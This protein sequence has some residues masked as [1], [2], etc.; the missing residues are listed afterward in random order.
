VCA[1]A[2]LRS[3]EATTAALDAAAVHAPQSLLALLLP[4]RGAASEQPPQAQQAQPQRHASPPRSSPEALSQVMLLGAVHPALAPHAVPPCYAPVHFA[5][6]ASAEAARAAVAAATAGIAAACAAAAAEAAR[7]D[8]DAAATAAA[9]AAA[10]AAQRAA[11]AA[12]GSWPG[13]TRS[14]AGET[15]VYQQQQHAQ[16]A[17]H[18]QQ[19]QQQQ[20][21]YRQAAAAA[22]ALCDDD[23]DDD[24]GFADAFGGE[25]SLLFGALPAC[26]FGAGAAS[27][28]DDPFVTPSALATA[29]SRLAPFEARLKFH[30]LAPTQLPRGLAPSLAEWMA[31]TAG[32]GVPASASACALS[33]EGHVAPGCT[34]LS[35]SGVVLLPPGAK[36]AP[37]PDGTRLGGNAA[38]LLAHLLASGE[39]AGDNAAL[40]RG[41]VSACVHGGGAASALNGQ[42]VAEP[43]GT[44]GRRSA[45]RGGRR[46]SSSSANDYDD[47][48]IE[49]EEPRYVLPPLRPLALLSTAPM[50]VS[51]SAPAGGASRGGDDGPRLRLRCRLHGQSFA[52]LGAAA[53]GARLAPGEHVAA[54]LPACGAEGVAL[55]DVVPGAAAPG[56]GDNTD[57]NAAP[58]VCAG[59]RP[60]VLTPHADVAAEIC[61]LARAARGRGRTGAEL[62]AAQR[63][64]EVSLS[65]LGHALRPRCA[66][67]L[68]A[69]AAAVALEHGLAATAARVLPAAARCDD[70]SAAAP[71]GVTLL[72]RA[73]RGGSA[74]CVRATLAAGGACGAVG[75][76]GP[77]GATPLHVAA[78]HPTSAGAAAAM[79]EG[80]ADAVLLWFTA[81]TAGGGAA[82]TPAALAAGRPAG[83]LTAALRGRLAC[84]GGAARA[85]LRAAAC[86]RA[87][88]LE[89]HFLSLD[90]A[91]CALASAP[92]GATPVGATAVAILRRA[93]AAEAAAP[94]AAVAG[95]ADAA[96][97]AAA[98]KRFEDAAMPRTARRQFGLFVL[99]F[100]ASAAMEYCLV[101]RVAAQ[102]AG[103]RMTRERLAAWRYRPTPTE[104]LHM[105]FGIWPL[106]L[107]AYNLLCAVLGAALVLSAAGRAL[108][109]AR[110]HAVS[111]AMFLVAFV[112]EL[113]AAEWSVMRAFGLAQHERV[114]VSSLWLTVSA[115]QLACACALLRLRTRTQLRLL[116][117]RYAMLV[118]GAWLP[119]APKPD[120]SAIECAIGHALV[121]AVAIHLLVGAR[122]RAF[123]AWRVSRAVAAARAAVVAAK[124]I[125]AAQAA[126][127]AGGGGPGGSGG[128]SS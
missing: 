56:G 28:L 120:C 47:D 118:A 51:S 25:A 38:A 13:A 9:A 24:G 95:A 67:P 53:D 109:A 26:D 127:G 61:S 101:C 12:H 82:S 83:A 30:D 81:R 77:G 88:T 31:Q 44:P 16:H 73:A 17:Q 115:L 8:A 100:A 46:S 114:R 99:W 96:H 113:P 42:P 58:L 119:T 48:A 76:A 63:A 92:L 74:A 39:E 94:L 19:A 90:A 29:A 6:S 14:S 43:P 102:P 41:R 7:A 18:A 50:A 117:L 49:T 98:L 27:F 55:F 108:Y 106:G 54:M 34:M 57:D 5:A 37:M 11:F 116:A 91:A 123:K 59:V 122:T 66:P 93:L 68:A 86:A 124:K 111:A 85:A 128:W 64:L 70:V 75:S 36:A 125:A 23:D 69:L 33:V 10:V 79:L 20:E 78:A 60:V 2:L 40:R 52:S 110:P 15:D 112:C 80:D 32:G 105:Y 22:A 72:H 89:E 103:V 35:V 65:A 87:D 97:D 71:G 107:C 121:Y 21:H 84:A 1:C 126:A 104:S 3:A 4:F 62:A 45:P